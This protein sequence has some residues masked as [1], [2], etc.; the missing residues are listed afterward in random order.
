[1]VQTCANCNQH[2]EHRCK[3]GR[4]D[5]CIMK[6]TVLGS[7][8]TVHICNSSSALMRF[9]NSLHRGDMGGSYSICIPTACW[10]VEQ[11]RISSQCKWFK[12]LATYH[13]PHYSTFSPWLWA[14]TTAFANPS[15]S[16]C[17]GIGNG[18]ADMT[19]GVPEGFGDGLPTN[20][21]ADGVMGYRHRLYLLAGSLHFNRKMPKVSVPLIEL[22][23]SYW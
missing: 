5:F 19:S 18:V 8:A 6:A 12:L 20:A 4:S 13:Q 9:S 2:I 16:S 17:F 23:V 3:H 10:P 21:S 22:L 11:L 1:M 15:P 7:S 14:A